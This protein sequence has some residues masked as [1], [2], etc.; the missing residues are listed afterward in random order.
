MRGFKGE[1]AFDLLQR[2]PFRFDPILRRFL[3]DKEGLLAYMESGEAARETKQAAAAAEVDQSEPKPW[4]MKKKGRRRKR[5]IKVEIFVNPTSKFKRR[6]IE[7]RQS[8]G[9]GQHA[10]FQKLLK[11]TGSFHLLDPSE[12]SG[13][14]EENQS[15]LAN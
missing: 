13:S 15:S 1:T 7:R 11:R 6:A 2:I 5:A 14:D 8:F 12:T 3:K 9:D 10:P 4:Q